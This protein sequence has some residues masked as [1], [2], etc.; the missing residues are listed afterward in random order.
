MRVHAS[1]SIMCMCVW[2][3]EHM[4]VSMCKCACARVYMRAFEEMYIVELISFF[5][6]FLEG[7]TGEWD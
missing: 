4:F 7:V 5:S 1:V 2:V 3:W 6:V